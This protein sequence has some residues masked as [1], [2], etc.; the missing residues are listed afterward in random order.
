MEDTWT[1]RDLPFLD[2]AVRLLD[3][4]YDVRVSDVAAAAGLDL[5]SAARALDALEGPYLKE[6]ARP[7]GSPGSWSMPKVTR[8]ARQAV[9]QWPTPETLV[10]RLAEAF[11]DAAENEPD[12]E[13]KNRLRQ[14]AGFLG[15][16]GRDVAA[17]VVSKV[18]L[19]TAGM[20]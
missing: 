4:D 19:H 6:F 17:E 5:E 11:G 12:S 15:S 20:G 1:N 8:A 7:M 2:V 14:V 18:I 13:R 16:T 3:E 10:S 9:G